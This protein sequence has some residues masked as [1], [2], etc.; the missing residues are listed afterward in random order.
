MTNDVFA[1]RK[2]A[3][4]QLYFQV[5]ILSIFGDIQ[6]TRSKIRKEINFYEIFLHVI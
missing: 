6:I 5:A 3:S 1:F 2:L 4:P